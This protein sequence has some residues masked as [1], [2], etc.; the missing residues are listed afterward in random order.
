M[1]L[2]MLNSGISTGVA[3][4]EQEINKYLHL[5][6]FNLRPASSDQVITLLIHLKHDCSNKKLEY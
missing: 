6:L 2:H 4:L 1:E 3:F 5:L